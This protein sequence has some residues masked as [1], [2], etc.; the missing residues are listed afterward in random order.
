MAFGGALIFI[1]VF[2]YKGIETLTVGCYYIFNIND[3]LQTS[4]N[5]KRGGTCKYQ[6]VQMFR[7]IE[8]LKRKQMTLMFQLTTIG[9]K[10]IEFHTAELGT[11]P[12]IGRATKAMLGGIANA[13]I[14]DA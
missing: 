1:R 4:L 2:G 10:Q 14:A 12:A 8:I 7:L 11:C 13:T 9:I 6:F 5:L 3:I